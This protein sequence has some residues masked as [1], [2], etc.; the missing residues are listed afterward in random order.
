VAAPAKYNLE[1]MQKIATEKGG[2]CLS[3]NY[4]QNPI[5]MIWKCI[6]GHIWEETPYRIRNGCWCPFC[7]GRRRTKKDFCN[8]IR[9]IAKSKGG[10]CLSKEYKTAHIKMKF[11][12]DSGHVWKCQ[13]NNIKNGRWCPYCSKYLTERKCRYIFEKTFNKKFPKYRFK[14]N[15]SLL[16]L[17]GYCKKLKLAFE[18]NGIQHY[19]F[20]KK[21][22]K[23]KEGFRKTKERDLCKKEWCNSHKVNLIVIPCQIAKNDQDLLDFLSPKLNVLDIKNTNSLRDLSEFYTSNSQL[24]ELKKIAKEKGGKL[25]STFYN[26]TKTRLQWQCKCGFIWIAVASSVKSG[27]WCRKCATK[28][29]WKNRRNLISHAK[30]LAKRNRGKCIKNVYA[31]LETKLKWE[32]EFGHT[33]ED[34][35]INVENGSW[36]PICIYKNQNSSSL[37]KLNQD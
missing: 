2:K 27:S 15:E 12:C 34:S 16:E 24:Q 8:E 37:E 26:G 9:K 36:C 18:Y 11:Q 7:S 20:I 32:C 3:D 31:T 23:T 10:K 33:W 4:S 6:K 17:D 21:W 1:D 28:K 13:P 29:T 35:C 30:N 14:C 19:K 25:L 22:H 5:K